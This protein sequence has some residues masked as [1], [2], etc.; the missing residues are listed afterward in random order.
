M[1][2]FTGKSKIY[3]LL[4]FVYLLIILYITLFSR[5]GSLLQ[6]C[7]VDLF[8]SYLLW[9][10]GNSDLGKEIILN[11]ALFVPYGYFLSQALVA[12]DE[13]G[14]DEA[15]NKNFWLMPLGIGLITSVSIEAAQYYYG[16]GL[17]ETDDLFNNLLGTFLGVCL[18]K[19][20]QVV[21]TRGGLRSCRNALA[22]LLM[23]AGIAGCLMSSGSAKSSAHEEIMYYD[24]TVA[25]LTYDGKNYDMQGICKVFGRDTPRYRIYLQ[26]EESGKKYKGNTSVSG[27]TFHA[28]VPADGSEKYKVNIL[29]DRFINLHTFT[30]I[31][32]DRVEY[33]SGRVV[34]P[35][36]AGTDLE[37]I[38]NGGILKAYD[39][40]YEVYV[41]QYRKR[42]YWL[43]GSPLD[44]SVS[45]VFL[46][47]T[48]EPERLPEKRK[49]FG[50]DNRWFMGGGNNELTKAMRCGKYRVF[51]RKIPEEYNVTAVRTGLYKYK[52]KEFLWSGYFRVE[53]Q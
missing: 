22:I 35:E 18:H 10:E 40:H 42:L 38:V 24:F 51:V 9:L 53:K 21:F 33:V 5:H 28:V 23:L 36:A 19:G 52:E 2:K 47:F 46:L 43:I 15:G 34:T 44:K 20:S 17:C 4:S 27:D 48:N 6:T 26:D 13:L 45:V 41:Y 16:L 1:I 31:N 3:I 49:K 50:F 30:Y 37:E 14:G 25:K 29:F 8:W 7:R 32:K 12:P 39:P 11:I